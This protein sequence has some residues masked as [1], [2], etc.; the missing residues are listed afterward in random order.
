[1]N[2]GNVFRSAHAFGAS[3]VFTIDA[4]YS[5]RRSRSDTALSSRHLPFYEWDSLD[6]LVLPRDCALVGVE[7]IDD[8]IDLPSFRHPSRAA[9]LLGPEKGSLAPQTLELCDHII[10]IPTRFCV[11]VATAGAIVLYDRTLSLGRFPLR[12]EHVGG[13]RA[14]SH[15]PSYEDWRKPSPKTVAGDRQADRRSSS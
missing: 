2:I 14:G 4:H 13:P 5:H 11:N 15:M 8:A 6:D 12:P 3:F 7:L 1:M 9:Y 10:K